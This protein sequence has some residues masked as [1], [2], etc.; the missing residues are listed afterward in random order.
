[1]GAAAGA[2]QSKGLCF[3]GAVRP[4]CSGFLI[5][6]ASAVASTGGQPHTFVTVVPVFNGQP[7]TLTNTVH[8]LPSY[9]SG[10][11]GYLRV[12]G[13]RRAIGVIGELGYGTESRLG[14]VHRVAI[15]GRER[16]EI[17]NFTVDGSAGPLG[18]EVFVPGRDCCSNR[19]HAYGATAEANVSY[20]DYI[21]I[22]GGADLVH[23]G[24]RTSYAARA[25]LRAGS[26]AAVATSIVV[27]VGAFVVISA[28]AS[29]T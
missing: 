7:Q 11:L 29:G 16:R 17:G 22:L 1:M 10:T 21:G 3:R 18:V 24:G 20:H 2:Q 25:G 26:W 13:D 5:F 12:V 28:L 14:N 4:E 23:G 8:D 6:E 27:G 9:F 19:V 15:M